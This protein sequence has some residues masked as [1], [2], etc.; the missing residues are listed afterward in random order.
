[1]AAASTSFIGSVYLR[2]DDVPTVDVNIVLRDN[3]TSEKAVVT[4]RVDTTWRR[5]SVFKTFTSA[6]SGNVWFQV[7]HVGKDFKAFGVMVEKRFNTDAYDTYSKESPS[8]YVSTTSAVAT[9]A[10]DVLYFPAA[11]V[12]QCK[13]Q[14]SMSLWLKTTGDLTQTSAGGSY[15]LFSAGGEQFALLLVGNG[16]EMNLWMGNGFVGQA[17]SGYA[18]G[19][20]SWTHFALTWDTDADDYNVYVNGALVKHLTTARP[21]WSDSNDL[22]LGARTGLTNHWYTPGRFARFAMWDT[23]LS[24]ADVELARVATMMIEPTLG[25]GKL[26]EVALGTS[27]IPTTGNQGYS[28]FR[29]GAMA[30]YD[31]TTSLATAADG[32]PAIEA[33]ALNDASAHSGMQFTLNRVNSILQSEAI[34][35]TWTDPASTTITA[36]VGTF[37]GSIT[38]GTITGTTGDGIQQSLATAAASTE[39]VGSLYVQCDG[40]SNVDGLLT[41]EGDSGGT[42]EVSTQTFTATSTVQRIHLRKA[43]TGSATGNVRM[44]ITVNQAGSDTLRV[45]GMQ[46]EARGGDPTNVPL[47]YYPTAYIKTTTTAVTGYLPILAYETKGNLNPAKGTLIMWINPFH[48]DEA[49]ATGNTPTLIGFPGHTTGFIFRILQ[50][51]TLTFQYD[52]GGISPVTLQEPINFTAYQWIQLAISWDCATGSMKLYKDGAVIDTRT[53]AAFTPMPLLKMY[54]GTDLLIGSTDTMEG[55]IDRIVIYGSQDDTFVSDD[56]TAHAAEYGR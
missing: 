17:Q 1:V 16:A 51:G 24:A 40:G 56:Y 7:E 9:R 12:D 47:L 43:F 27:L 33:Y 39:W 48:D 15:Y 46:L 50:S 23:V 22:Y 35:T 30:Y 5:F 14:G 55:L 19:R 38:Y 18:L 6:A 8:P 52:L 3:T 34:T 13:P 10:G 54:I 11:D 4:C 32:V 31:S 2:S 28:Y 25:T 41:I 49:T 21:P 45:G 20:N 53:G 44:K 36:G 26:F 29:R 37:L 42:P